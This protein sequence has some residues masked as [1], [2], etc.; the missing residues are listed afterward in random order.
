MVS[1]TSKR[2]R[3]ILAGL[4]AAAVIGSVFQF[5]P[6]QSF[7]AS[8]EIGPGNATLGFGAIFVLTEDLSTWR[9]QG[10]IK[11]AKFTGLQL[12]IPTQKRLSDD[13]V[14]LYLDGNRPTDELDAIRLT[15]N[16]ISLLGTFLETGLETA[17]ILEDDVDFGVEIREQMVL[18]SNALWRGSLTTEEHIAENYTR[19]DSM[20]ASEQAKYPYGRDTWDIFWLGHYG[21]EFTMNTEVVQYNDP[22]ALPWTHLTS[23]FNNYYA[24]LKEEEPL[25]PQQILRSAAPMS[26][27][28]YAVTRQHAFWLL[29][30]LRSERAQTID[31]SLH[32]ACKGLSQRCFA[33]VPEIMHHHKVQ[34]EK[35]IGV[36][37]E[38]DRDHS[39]AWPVHRHRYT[40]NIQYSARC[41]AE[42]V[43][44]WNGERRQ[45]LPSKYDEIV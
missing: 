13:E 25:Q 9:T 40:F 18:L 42:G 36:V 27:Y 26:T 22:H 31:Y 32:V 21:V 33:P 44:E 41:N 28:A 19:D 8:T 14:A 38:E 35:K 5:Y 23:P 34:G 2:R 39:T 20:L 30:H 6:H 15:L 1:N 10:L 11:A 4:A 3:N 17:L 12:T 7:T 37:G 43:G 16:T 24:S 29:R 45:C